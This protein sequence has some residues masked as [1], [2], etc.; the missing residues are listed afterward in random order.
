MKD[1]CIFK[2]RFIE[3][4]WFKTNQCIASPPLSR[5]YYMCSIYVLL[6]L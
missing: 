4:Y 2:P 1:T 5:K 6:L 3:R